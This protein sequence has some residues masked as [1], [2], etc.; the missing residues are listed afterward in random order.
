M[1]TIIREGRKKKEGRE[2]SPKADYSAH[3]SLSQSA[4]DNAKPVLL[5]CWHAPC[6]HKEMAKKMGYSLRDL[7]YPESR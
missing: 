4:A 3:K 2:N 1:M 7:D 5:F 6:N